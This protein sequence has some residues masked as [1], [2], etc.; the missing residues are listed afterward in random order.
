MPEFSEVFLKSVHG[1]GP[2]KKNY[3]NKCL[4]RH[5]FSCW[6]VSIIWWIHQETK[7]KNC[8]SLR[9]PYQRNPNKFPHQRRQLPK[10]GKCGHWRPSFL[11]YNCQWHSATCTHLLALYRSL[12]KVSN[13]NRIYTS[14]VRFHLYSK[15]SLSKKKY[16]NLH[17]VKKVILQDFRY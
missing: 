17:K 5:K 4:Y 15:K 16:A 14:D 7:L 11:M 12:C 1:W 2:R 9:T 3:S 8:I 10:C 6:V 13:C